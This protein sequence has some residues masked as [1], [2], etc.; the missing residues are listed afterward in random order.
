MG[1]Y[2]GEQIGSFI[3]RMGGTIAGLVI[4]MV[5][6]YIGAQH[7]P[8]NP[9]GVAAATVSPT[10]HSTSGR[11][12]SLDLRS[13]LEGS[14]DWLQMVLIAIPLFIRISAPMQSPPMIFAL[15]TG[16]TITVSLQ[17]CFR[18]RSRE[19]TT[20]VCRRLLLGR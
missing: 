17:T 18:A 3:L 12:I 2:T 19:L 16:V 7:G 6:W 5:A 11:A 9:Y 14:A 8:G 1:V 15:M 10:I 20:T 4:G 13:Q